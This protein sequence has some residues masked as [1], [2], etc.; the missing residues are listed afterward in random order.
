VSV[1]PI[2]VLGD[3]VLRTPAAEVDAFDR[4]LRRLADDMFETMYAAPGVGLAAPQIG[5]SIRLFVY[6]DGRESKGVLA[7]PAILAMDGEVL[8]DEGCLSVP[9][10]YR[11]T[12]RAERVRIR[13]RDLD[14]SPLEL[15]GEGLLARIFQ[16]ETDHLNGTIYID[17]LGEE[18]RR[19]V[20][21]ELRERELG[22]RPPEGRRFSRP[23]RRP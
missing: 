3:P 19:G 11:E 16:H 1:I 4:T 14:G 5:L 22:G 13:G 21:A 12:P 9:G 2:R 17:R 18:A 15:Q 10:I 8:E 7:N 20:L 23:G 6:D